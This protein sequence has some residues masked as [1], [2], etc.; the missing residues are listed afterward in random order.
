MTKPIT[1]STDAHLI[2][3]HIRTIHHPDKIVIE[4]E[5]IRWPHPHEP[6]SEWVPVTELPPDAD[7][8]DIDQ[9]VIKVLRRRKY[10]KVCKECDERKPAGLMWEGN[11]CQGCGERNHHVCF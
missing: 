10:F 2:K 1:T 3:H 6:E 11:I 5:V 4:V 9:A 7:Q 8:A